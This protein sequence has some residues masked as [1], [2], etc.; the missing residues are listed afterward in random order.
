MQT[1]HDTRIGIDPNSPHNFHG[2][3]A[4]R[5]AKAH[6]RDYGAACHL[7]ADGKAV[8]YYMDSG[9]LRQ[10]NLGPFRL[11][12]PLANWKEIAR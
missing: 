4:Q 10:R 7:R 1:A 8:L 12:R 5:I 6:A 2:P 3:G 9:R 11:V